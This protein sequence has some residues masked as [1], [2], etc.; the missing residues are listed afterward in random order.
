MARSADTRLSGRVDLD[1][2]SLFF[3]EAGVGDPPV[4][5]V[6]GGGFCDHH[7]MAPLLDRLR[8]RHRVVTIDLRG[9]GK[10][11]PAPDD[12]Y[13]ITVFAEDLA[14]VCERLALARPVVV[15]HSAGGNAALELAARHPHLPSALVLLDAGPLQWPPETHAMHRGLIDLLRS[16]NGTAVQRAMAERMMP[17]SKEFPEREQLL[18]AVTGA[19]PLVLAAIIESDLEWNGEEA[20]AACKV[21]VLHILA[22]KPLV[23]AD[24]FRKACPHAV[25]EQPVGAGHFHQ[26]VAPDQVNAMIERFLSRPTTQT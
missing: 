26:L 5:L 1:G 3:E 17:A 22:D 13:S 4:L 7:Y 25:I 20:A 12:R 19:S 14:A 15:G 21:P 10:S 16:D 24:D 9:H 11:D 2:M 23:S 18:E 8:H 6:H